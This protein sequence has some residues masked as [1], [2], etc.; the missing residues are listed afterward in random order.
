MT[1]ELQIWDKSPE[2]LYTESEVFKNMGLLMAFLRPIIPVELQENH[3]TIL[4]N[5]GNSS[6]T[7]T[8]SQIE[9]N[10]LTELIDANTAYKEKGIDVIR[11]LFL[12]EFD[13]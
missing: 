10:E 7:V 3:W 1:L 9:G 13:E 6:F 4:A 5:E 11:K 8:H 12:K 2:L